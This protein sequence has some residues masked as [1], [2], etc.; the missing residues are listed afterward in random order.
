[1]LPHR[2]RVK[3]QNTIV[4]PITPIKR[5][6]CYCDGILTI[7]SSVLSFLYFSECFSTGHHVICA[8][9]L[10]L[11][12]RIN[13]RVVVCVIVSNLLLSDKSTVILWLV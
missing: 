11:S 10:W 2:G 1:M 7:K 8:S 4:L 3:K 12:V 13:V 9:E 5:C 6:T